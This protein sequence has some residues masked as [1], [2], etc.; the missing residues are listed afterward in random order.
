MAEV[1]SNGK[2]MSEAEIRKVFKDLGLSPD[3]RPLQI[4]DEQPVPVVHFTIS[5][6]SPPLNPR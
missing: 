2:Q 5:G 1:A 6:N 4:K 3:H